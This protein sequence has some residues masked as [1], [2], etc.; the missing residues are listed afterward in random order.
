MKSRIPQILLRL[1]YKDWT[2]FLGGKPDALYLRLRWQTVCAVTGEMMWHSSRKWLLSE[3]MTDSEIVQTALLAVLTAEEHEAREQFHFDGK[4]VFGPHYDVRALA[5]VEARDVRKPKPHTPP[6][7]R[8][9]KGEDTFEALDTCD[10]S[11]FD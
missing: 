10:G 6:P 4:A 3:H 1:R 9:C 8:Y 7:C 5:S 2:F 11:C